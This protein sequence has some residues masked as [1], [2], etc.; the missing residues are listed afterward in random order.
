MIE[1]IFK[2]QHKPTGLFYCSRKGRWQDTK[3]NLSQKG[4]FYLEEKQAI[5][6]YEEDCKR[7]DINKA[8]IEKYGLPINNKDSWSYCKANKEE[9]IIK[10]YALKEVE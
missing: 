7:A 2:I 4:N 3:T 5:K 9:F 10:K 1:H 8:Q 6:V